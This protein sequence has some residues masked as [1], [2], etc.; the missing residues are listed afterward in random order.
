MTI[1]ELI[2]K[3]Q[4]T[5]KG[6]TEKELKQDVVIYLSKGNVITDWTTDIWYVGNEYTDRTEQ[7]HQACIKAGNW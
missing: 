7:H 3:L 2:K 5:K 1:D 4:E 6:L